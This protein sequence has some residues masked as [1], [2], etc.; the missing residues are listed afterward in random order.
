MGETGKFPNFLTVD[1]FEVGNTMQVTN[2]TNG[3]LTNSISGMNIKTE[4]VLVCSD[5][6]NGRTTI[7]LTDPNSVFFNFVVT[8]VM[9]KEVIQI[10]ISENGSIPLLHKDFASGIYF[11]YFSD[12]QKNIYQGKLRLN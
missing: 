11:F 7:S 8:D 10:P 2:I 5:F 6:I 4:S 3:I 12:K 9:G 1:F